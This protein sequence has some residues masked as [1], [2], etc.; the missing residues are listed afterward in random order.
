[1]G[2]LIRLTWF[3]WASCA[4]GGK[5]GTVA[6]IDG[7]PNNVTANIQVHGDNTS[8]SVNPSTGSLVALRPEV[9]GKN[10]SELAVWQYIYCY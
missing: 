4:V 3:M 9:G 6:V 7:K 1:M 8:V 2:L 10:L 5:N